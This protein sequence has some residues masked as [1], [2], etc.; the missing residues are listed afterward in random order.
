MPALVEDYAIIDDQRAVLHF[1]EKLGVRGNA[2]L[3]EYRDHVGYNSQAVAKRLGIEQNQIKHA[4]ASGWTVLDYDFP[5]TVETVLLDAL[6][7][8]LSREHTLLAHKG[9]RK[10]ISHYYGQ[11]LTVGKRPSLWVSALEQHEW[12]L[13]ED[14]QRRTPGDVLL[15]RHLDFEDAPIAEIDRDFA[16]RLKQEGIRFGV[17]I[18]R[19]P[20]LRRLEL[21]GA[22]DLPDGELAELLEGAQAAVDAGEVTPEELRSAL[23][24][25]TLRGVPILDRVVREA[26]RPRAR[27]DLGGWVVALS[28]VERDLAAAVDRVEI[29]VPSTTTGN[30]A[31]AYLSEIWKRKPGSVDEIRTN[32]ASAYRY[33]LE[34]VERDGLDRGVWRDAKNEAQLYGKGRWY[35]ISNSL[36]VDDVRS[37][38]I[39]Q[40]LPDNRIAITSAHLGDTQGQ[41]RLVAEELGIALL[42]TEIE[43]RR[44]PRLAR[45]S[46]MGNLKTLADAL[47]TLEGRSSLGKISCRKD[48]ALHVHGQSH[49]VTAYLADGELMV[50]GDPVDFGAEAAGQLVE[51]FQLG[52]R[53]NTVPWLTAAIY[54]LA[55]DELFSQNL[56]V[57]ASGLGLSLSGLPRG[58][59]HVTDVELTDPGQSR[60]GGETDG[61]QVEP[62]QATDTAQVEAQGETL[63]DLSAD[64][65]GSS[66]ASGSGRPGLALDTGQIDSAAET[67]EVADLV[68]SSYTKARATAK[69]NSLAEQLK[70]SL[71]GEIVPIHTEDGTHEPRTSGEDSGG[72][73]GDEEYREAAAQYERE[74]NREPEL[75]DPLQI[76]W[77]IRSVD[78]KTNEVRLI[79]VKGKGRAWDEDEVVELSRAQVRKAFEAT[80]GQTAGT[81][82]LYVVEKTAD[83]A[84]QVLPIENPVR[85][86]AKWILSGR[87]WRM[88]AEDPKHITGHHRH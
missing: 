20:V 84:F 75:G 85:V 10:A 65:A 63:N 15:D 28:S 74:A 2:T 26:G 67:P 42:S 39:R 34:D 14:G 56:K 6:Q 50:V 71:K 12:L 29:A 83:N 43:L 80:D 18:V 76:G 23:H 33:V 31:L 61:G 69:Q 16:N 41:I 73:L 48:L 82:Y 32:V 58:R 36:V 38:F 88:V 30:Q 44:G 62:S 86:A 52:Q 17:N 3:K 21:Q 64:Q 19:S 53:G 77:D 11:H 60:S 35:G 66:G 81:W 47:A 79:E 5:F 37:P 4:N 40:L 68:G 57:L 59:S 27:S 70:C 51:H 13:C 72:V 55:A 7:R 1:F 87:A 46:W 9:K 8:W 49:Q 45:P 24:S 78:P 25:V 22:L 54:S